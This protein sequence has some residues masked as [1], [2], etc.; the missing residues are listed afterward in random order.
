MTQDHKRIRYERKCGSC[1]C[2]GFG[3]AEM[4]T[5]RWGAG[6]EWGKIMSLDHSRE[7]YKNNVKNTEGMLDLREGL[8]CV[9]KCTCKRKAIPKISKDML[10][11]RTTT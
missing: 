2:S 8:L 5:G 4:R 10:R 1:D 3:M 7:I 6:E 9:R 11:P